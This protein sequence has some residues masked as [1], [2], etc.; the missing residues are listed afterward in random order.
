MPKANTGNANTARSG[1]A[2]AAP[3][4]AAAPCPAARGGA[5]SRSPT[6]QPARSRPA[7][8]SAHAWRVLPVPE[9]KV[10]VAARGV[11]RT[12]PR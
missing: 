3:S 11:T 8:S 6:C 7:A 2:G 9:K 5:I 10:T 12:G 1:A 4:A